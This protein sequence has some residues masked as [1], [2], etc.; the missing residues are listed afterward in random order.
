MTRKTALQGFLLSLLMITICA[1][2][3][4][5]PVFDPA[6]IDSGAGWF[7]HKHPHGNDS[8]CWR[9][10]VSCTRMLATF[11]KG[12][13][14]GYAQEICKPQPTSWCFV[15]PA[16]ESISWSCKVDLASCNAK[17]NRW[18]AAWFQSGASECFEVK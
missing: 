10:E 16:N 11:R 2:R 17:R 8:L 9:S 7:C 3:K 1:C 4:E 6:R 18:N 13:E 14:K 12:D 15:R 5:I